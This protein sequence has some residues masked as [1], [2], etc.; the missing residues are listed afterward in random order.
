MSEQSAPPESA[1]RRTAPTVFLHIGTMKTGTSFLQR[2]LQR[3]AA[4]L[5]ADGIT[6]PLENSRWAL[7]VRAARDILEIK[8]KPTY[9]GWAAMLDAIQAWPGRAA[10]VSMEFYSLASAARAEKIVAALAPSDV[11]VIIT[12]R[13]LV[14][15]M[16]LSLIHI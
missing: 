1:S 12:A 4:V 14:R 2:V 5:A 13:D 6:Y 3:N 8:G 9:G 7:Q 15:V 16:P 10:V 11:Q